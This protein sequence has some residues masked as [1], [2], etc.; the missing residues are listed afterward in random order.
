LR[1]RSV[2]GI[3]CGRCAH[4]VLNTTRGKRERLVVRGAHDVALGENSDDAA[5]VREHRRPPMLC[6]M[7]SRIAVLSSSFD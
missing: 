7:S 6:L 5:V 1:P 4:H 2:V 3:A